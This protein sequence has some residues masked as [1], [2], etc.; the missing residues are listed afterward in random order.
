MVSVFRKAL[1]LLMNMFIAASLREAISTN[2]EISLCD[3]VGSFTSTTAILGVR[4]RIELCLDQ[5]MAARSGRVTAA[6]MEKPRCD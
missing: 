4:F 5:V 1:G 2:L 6:D 3:F